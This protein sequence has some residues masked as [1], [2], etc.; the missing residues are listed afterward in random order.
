[1]L[2]RSTNP[3]GTGVFL[4]VVVWAQTTLQATVVTYPAPASRNALR[5]LRG[6]GR[7]PEGGRLHGA[8]AGPAVCRARSRISAGPTPS[9]ISIWPGRVKVQDHVQALAAQ[10]RGPARMSPDVKLRLEGD[11]TLIL[12]LAGPAQAQRRTGRQEGSAAAV[13]QSDGR[14]PAQRRVRRT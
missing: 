7:R 12:S 14:E 6:A 3:F 5:R 9:P 11:H 4:C 1:M 8:R 2:M 10:H 13:C